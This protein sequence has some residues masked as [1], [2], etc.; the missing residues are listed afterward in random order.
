LRLAVAV[1]GGGDSLASLLLLRE[2]GHDVLALHGRFLPDAGDPKSIQAEAG[3]AE[4]CAGLG[5]PL[6]VLDLRDAFESLVAAPFTA[7]YLAGRTPNPCA[8]CNAAMKF[9]LLLD[10]ALR[11][12]AEALATGHYARSGAHPLHGWALSRGA[13]PVK[14]QSYFLS[15][16]PRNRLMRALFPLADARKADVRADL[17]GRGLTP[18]VPEESQEI[19]FVPGDDYRAFLAARTPEL[20][21]PGPAVLP[22][23]TP[24]G[25]H[26]GLWRATI[27]Q[28]RGLGLA[29]SEPLYALDKRCASNTLVVAPRAAL[30]TDGFCARE[31][32]VLVD[33]AG[34]PEVALAQTRYREQAAPAR[35]ELRGG[36]LRVRFVEPRTRPAPGQVAALYGADG[37]VLAGAVVAGPLG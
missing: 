9:G 19:C 33:P 25:R 17:A 22:D 12:G 3:L 7:E 1:S 21:G 30:L 24:V 15:L 29:W 11:L 13:D 23:G 35:W 34:W 16:V 18:P 31:V 8:R 36:E 14:D 5:V 20:P 10:E 26:Q 4:G 2:A 32:N 6:H 27:G 28:R 37:V